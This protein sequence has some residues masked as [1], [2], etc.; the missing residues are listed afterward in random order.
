MKKL[1]YSLI[2]LFIFIQFIRP[3]KNQSAD[4]SKDIKTVVDVPEKV[5][6]ILQRSCYDCHSNNTNYPWYDQIQPVRWWVEHHI[7]E[8]K[9]HLN[10]SEFTQYSFDKQTDKLDEIGEVLDNDE[11]PLSSYTFM[12]KEARL[13]PEEKDMVINWATETVNARDE[14]E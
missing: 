13:T 12:H 11:M 14:A 7:K 9:A 3:D 8:G 5:H 10:F 4:H 2:A 1:L 6:K